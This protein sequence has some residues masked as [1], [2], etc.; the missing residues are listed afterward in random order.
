MGDFWV[1]GYGS[2][3]WRPGFAHVETRRARLYGYRRSLCVY[4]FVHRGTRERPGLVLGLDRGG[5]CVGLAFR[6]PGELRD[7]V[8]T[9]LR[10]RELVTSVYLER[11]LDIRL[12]RNGMTGGK[13]V[14]AV[15]YIVDRKHEQY[16]GG[17]DAAHAADVVRGAVGQ[18]GRN[19]D[20]LFSTLEHL[21]ALGISDH[22]LEEV[23]R[24]LA[25]L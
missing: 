3:I 2:L 23:A 24:R 25:P 19:E 7:E 11:S 8:L 4:S 1:F 22:W 16:A 20:Y 9:Y 17:L 6:V 21:E 15:A 10:E 5:S 13:T 18:S 12:D 14:R